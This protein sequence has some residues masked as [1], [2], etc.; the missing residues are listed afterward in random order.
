[1]QGTM[2][3]HEP[4]TELPKLN[5]TEIW[6]IWNLSGDAHPIHLHLV[7]FE[8]LDRYEILFDGGGTEAPVYTEDTIPANPTGTYLVEQPTVDHNGEIGQGFRVGNPTMGGLVNPANL[9]EYF[10]KSPK[11]MVTALPGQVTRIKATFDKAGRYVWHC[12]ILSR[13]CC[14]ST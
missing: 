14:R 1:M 13:K 10:E 6:E 5:D 12:H 2:L 4:T 8:I 7:H 9:T 11:D 3:W